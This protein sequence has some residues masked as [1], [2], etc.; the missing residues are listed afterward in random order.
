M[1][2]D[3]LE[4]S[5]SFSKAEYTAVHPLF[6][7][8][9]YALPLPSFGGLKFAFTEYTGKER[10]LAERLVRRPLLLKPGPARPLSPARP[11]AHAL[12]SPPQ[13]TTL[14]GEVTDAFSRDNSYLCA[15]Y[16]RGP[17]V[18]KAR[19]WQQ[20]KGWPGHVVRLRWL[21]DCARHGVLLPMGPQ[22]DPPPP[23]P[24]PPDG[25]DDRRQSH[26][27]RASTSAAAGGGWRDAAR[28]DRRQSH[29]GSAS[30]SS[31]RPSAARARRRV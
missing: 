25:V 11:S 31:A 24:P 12:R 16:Q 10:V 5:L 30:V 9:A 3:W 21:Y 19:Q 22:Y 15:L 14:G 6:A 27:G 28:D 7:P 2:L 20:R 4:W 26:D 13:V 18:E 23:P 29:D 17:K 8:L 1:T